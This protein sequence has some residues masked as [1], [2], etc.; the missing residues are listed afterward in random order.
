MA[1][2][3]IFTDSGCD[4]PKKTLTEW[5]VG[6]C[7]LTYTL[8]DSKTGIT[9]C[10]SYALEHFNIHRRPEELISF[11]GPPLKEQFILNQ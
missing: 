10:V 2:Y 4:I 1:A 8:T 9:N 11:V 5:G 3:K 6:S 7:S